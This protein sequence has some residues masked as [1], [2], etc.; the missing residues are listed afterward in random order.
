M[1]DQTLQELWKIK[2]DIAKEHNYDVDSLVGY[3]RSKHSAGAASTPR[4]D[5]REGG[6]RPRFRV[7]PRGRST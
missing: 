5:Q 3:L 7:L 1:T 2:D 6:D 4:P